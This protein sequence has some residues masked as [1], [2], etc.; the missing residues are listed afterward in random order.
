[1]TEVK[2]GDAVSV[3]YE[4]LLEDG[5]VFESSEESGIFEFK[6][7][8][9][10]AMPGFEQAIIGMEAGETKKIMMDPINAYGEYKK[11]LIHTVKRSSWAKDAEIKPGIIVGMTMDRDGQ[12]HKVPAMITATSGDE[13]TVDYNHPLAGKKVIYIITLEKINS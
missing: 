11:E 10:L 12:E 3:K 13:V 2:K 8:D 5:T 4:G 9:G 1:M 7:G 6:L